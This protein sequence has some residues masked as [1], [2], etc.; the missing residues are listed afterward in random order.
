MSDILC[1]FGVVHML[2]IYTYENRIFRE[3]GRY[4]TLPYDKY[5]L[6]TN[7]V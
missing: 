4:L 7:D 5:P 2:Y 3:K 6:T 1:S